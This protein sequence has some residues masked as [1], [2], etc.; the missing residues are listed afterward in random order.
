MSDKKNDWDKVIIV[1][2][3]SSAWGFGLSLLEQFMENEGHTLVPRSYFSKDDFWLGA[4]V[5]KQRNAYSKGML[6]KQQEEALEGMPGW[7]WEWDEQ[8]AK[9]NRVW[10]EKCECLREFVRDNGHTR[11]PTKYVTKGGFRLNSWVQKQKSDYRK[12]CLSVVRIKK[13]EKMHGWA[14][15]AKSKH[16]EWIEKYNCLYEF[17]KREG[18]AHVPRQFVLKNGLK[19]GSWIQTQRY[20]YKK[21]NLSEDRCHAL[22]N[23]AGWEWEKKDTVWKKGL[24]HLYKYVQQNGTDYVRDDYINVKGRITDSRGKPAAGAYIIGES[25]PLEN[26]GVGETTEHTAAIQ[27]QQIRGRSDYDGYYEL[28][29]FRAANFYKVFRYLINTKKGVRGS[30]QFFVDITARAEGF[31]Q[32]SNKPLR[33]PL[34]SQEQVHRARRILEAYSQVA[35]RTGDK[36]YPENK[37]QEYPLADSTG[38]TLT[39]V[40]I[41]LDQNGKWTE[42]QPANKPAV[43][44]DFEGYFADSLAGGR[45]LELLWDDKDRDLRDADEIL[46][47]VRKGLRRYEGS[48]NILR[49]VGNLFIWGKSPQ[50]EKA[51]EIMYHASG[52]PDRDLYGDAIYFGLSVADKKTPA[53]LRAM[54]EVAMKTGDYYNVTGRILWGCRDQ[55]EELVAALDPYLNS[56]DPS[57]RQKARD[58]KDYFTD[59]EAFLEKR[60]K[61]HEESV[62]EQ[63]GDRLGQFRDEMLSGD[64]QTRLDTL[65]FSLGRDGVMSIIDESFLGPFDAC[66]RDSDPGVRATAARMMGYK[67]VWSSTEQS[68]EVIEILTRLLNDPDRSVRGAAVY[69]GLSTVRIPDKELSAKMLAT[70]LD[71]REVNYYGRVIWG[72]RR[73]KQACAEILRDWM[74]QAARDSQRAVKA[75]EIFEDVLGEPLPEEYARRFAGK[76][77]DAHEGLAAMCI[78]AEPIS[79]DEL[80]GQIFK[81][82]EGSDLTEKVLDLYILQSRETASAMFICG[83][84]TDQNAVRDA[85]TKD[86]AFQVAGYTHGRIGPT[87]SG[88]IDSL[89]QFRERNE[90]NRVSLPLP[91]M[92]VNGEEDGPTDVVGK[93]N[94]PLDAA[95]QEALETVRGFVSAVKRKRYEVA[96]L[97]LWPESD[98]IKN[99]PELN[100]VDDFKNVTIPDQPLT[101][102]MD[103]PERGVYEAFLLSSEFVSNDGENGK[104]FFILTDLAAF[105]PES[106]KA[107]HWA[108]REL[109]FLR[110][111]MKGDWR[112]GSWLFDG[113]L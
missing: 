37:Q 41:V 53:I 8:D 76:R 104:L 97:R 112:S 33:V 75:Y 34:A 25:T 11:V 56:D 36:E 49:W 45:A 61:R 69:Y 42:Q 39:G 48:G 16:D 79:A 27:G 105:Y 3:A 99:L 89:E 103:V 90:Y 44:V 28:K 98:I 59:S 68:L 24:E 22:E 96:A 100:K 107:R 46:E 14:W 43:E 29:G 108:I 52:S 31:M 66:L 110:T 73:N 7:V 38:G 113:L 83:N 6:S 1:K 23:I 10:L 57:V 102:V 87:G 54:V 94:E 64:S 9:R 20:N 80:K 60:A 82:L 51:I 47:T 71:D 81:C 58:V 95:S 12:R 77:S 4:W 70:I 74:D 72:L 92:S 109:T 26:G 62:R 18:H 93:S 15:N 50:N 19:L 85:L 91:S 88:W 40:D 35:I 84:L 32:S 30:Y 111:S 13:L 55:K 106:Y 21:G 65:R 86:K 63:Y 101:V 67:F 78:A 5:R 17:V 2:K